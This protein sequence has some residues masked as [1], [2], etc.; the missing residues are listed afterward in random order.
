M[1]ET[2]V[3]AVRSWCQIKA[4]T[5][6]SPDKILGRGQ[7]AEGRGQRAIGLE[8]HYGIIISDKDITIPNVMGF[9][10]RAVKRKPE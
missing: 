4:F 5:N 7:R 10:G 9:V 3:R 1:N 8:D 6:P 2:V